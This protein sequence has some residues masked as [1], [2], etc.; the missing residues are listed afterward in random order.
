MPL[1]EY[2]C[3]DCGQVSEVLVL[4]AEDEAKC[5]GCQGENLKKLMSAS[6]GRVNNGPGLPGAGDTAC[7]GSAPG[8]AAGCAGP[9]SCCGKG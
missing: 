9:G 6:V 3:L 1:Y 4:S 8:Q 7:C 2:L 5:G